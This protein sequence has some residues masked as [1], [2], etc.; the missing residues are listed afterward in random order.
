VMFVPSLSIALL[1]QTV[2]DY[3]VSN[4]H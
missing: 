2:P 4:H 3:R 1:F